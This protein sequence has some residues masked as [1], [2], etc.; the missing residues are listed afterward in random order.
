MMRTEP[1]GSVPPVGIFFGLG[2]GSPV[3]PGIT[4]PLVPQVSQQLLRWNR[5]QI[6]SF[7]L[8]LP[9]L[10]QALHLGAG[11]QV[12]FGQAGAQVSHLWCRWKRGPQQSWAGLHVS[13]V[14]QRG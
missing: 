14:L 8:G 13:Q 5:P 4:A 6:R 3:L 12:V 2:I 9:Q 10:S 11:Q 1:G 7:R